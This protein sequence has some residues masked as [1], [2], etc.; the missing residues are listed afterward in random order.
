MV[1]APRPWNFTVCQISDSVSSWLASQ[2]FVQRSGIHRYVC[3]CMR[4]Y[5]NYN[6]VGNVIAGPYYYRLMSGKERRI[7]R[8]RISIRSP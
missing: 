4:V 8:G 7:P 3:V 6:K 2:R 5:I 1:H